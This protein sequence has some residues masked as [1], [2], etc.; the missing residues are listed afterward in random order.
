VKS[1][2]KPRVYGGVPIISR[3]NDITPQ[4][5]GEKTVFD[6]ARQEKFRAKPIYASC[7][8]PRPLPTGSG[9]AGPSS[10]RAFPIAHPEVVADLGLFKHAHDAA[11]SSFT[12]PPAGPGFLAAGQEVS[13][14]RMALFY[15]TINF[16]KAPGSNLIRPVVQPVPSEVEKRST[17]KSIFHNWG[18]TSEQLLAEST[19]QAPAVGANG[20][21]VSVLSIDNILNKAGDNVEAPYG[22]TGIK[23]AS[24]KSSTLG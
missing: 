23:A 21:N 15:P 1:A 16:H 14:E 2:E 10:Y 17:G 7:A 13:H 18:M 5:I 19:F 8:D 3:P 24:R 11:R 4:T 20:T 12:K 22:S 9:V 6:K